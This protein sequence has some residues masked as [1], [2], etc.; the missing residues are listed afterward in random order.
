MFLCVVTATIEQGQGKLMA[1]TRKYL[2]HLL[3][4]TGITPA[5]SEE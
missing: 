1:T 4:N 2:N 3:Q 5:C